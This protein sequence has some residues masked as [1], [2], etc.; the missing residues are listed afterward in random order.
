MIMDETKFEYFKGDGRILLRDDEYKF[1]GKW[2]RVEMFGAESRSVLQYRRPIQPATEPEAEK[3]PSP[4]PGSGEG[5][6]KPC[7][8]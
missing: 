3:G 2:W 6:A 1:L 5:F 4:A 7:I 8:R